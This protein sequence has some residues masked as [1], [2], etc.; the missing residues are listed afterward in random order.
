[1][2]ASPENMVRHFGLVSAEQAAGM[3]KATASSDVSFDVYHDG[4]QWSTAAIE[5][6]SKAN[7]AHPGTS[8]PVPTRRELNEKLE[9]ADGK[10]AIGIEGPREQISGFLHRAG[11]TDV[12]FIPPH[13]S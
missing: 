12:E 1:M 10:I 11:L 5:A 3:P 2:A 7:H 6:Q 13:V 4:G 9:S 8:R